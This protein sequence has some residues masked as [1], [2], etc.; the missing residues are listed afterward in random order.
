MLY[1]ERR[2]TLGVEMK[3]VTWN[4]N[5]S[6]A[7]ANVSCSRSSPK[8]HPTRSFCKKRKR[9]SCSC[10]HLCTGSARFRRISR[11]LAWKC[12]V[13][14]SS[15]PAQE[16]SFFPKNVTDARPP[17]DFETRVV[18]AHSGDYRFR[19]HV[20][21]ER[22]KRFCREGR[23][24]E[25]ARRLSAKRF[26]GKK[27]IIA[28]DLNVARTPVDV[29]P[30]SAQFDAVIGQTR[31]RTR[32]LFEEFV[33]R[34][35]IRRRVARISPPTTTASLFVVA[36]LAQRARTQC[37]LATRLRSRES[38]TL[39]A[40]AKESRIRRGIWVER[41]RASWSSR[42]HDHREPPSPLSRCRR[43]TLRQA[44]IGPRS[45]M[46]SLHPDVI[47][48]RRRGRRIHRR[49]SGLRRDAR[50]VRLRPSMLAGTRSR[51]TSA[52]QDPLV[53]HARAH[54]PQ[55]ANRA[56]V[57]CRRSREAE[58]RISMIGQMPLAID[59]LSQRARWCRRSAPDHAG[60]LTIRRCM[61]SRSR[62]NPPPSGLSDDESSPPPSPT[63]FPPHAANENKS[64]AAPGTL[65]W[66]RAKNR[67]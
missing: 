5:G 35:K 43:R 13:F 42:S 4:V 62:R 9:R 15:H 6:R 47:A 36:V 31:R 3:I 51:R 45:T 11:D 57:S 28:G 21:A 22:R 67:I 30:S 25:G 56:R 48:R 61:R 8:S 33:A 14:G 60:I 44:W 18:E 26:A 38:R 23:V 66:Q 54:P 40:T 49:K 29:H 32:L 63:N 16:K 34:R 10:R 2:A 58:A 27:V 64:S 50:F 41:P 17:F 39:A 55:C 37:R 59:A 53:V 1:F 7:R 12:R 46:P 20:L 65:R 52:G 24:H 19:F